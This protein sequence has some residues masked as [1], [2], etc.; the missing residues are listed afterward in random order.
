MNCKKCGKRLSD[1]ARY[2]DRCGSAVKGAA[3]SMSVARKTTSSRGGTAVATK[4][5]TRSKN[6]YDAYRKKKMQE[7]LEQRRRRRKVRIAILWIILL[8]IIGAV[9][10]GLYAYTYMM[11]GGT[12]ENEEASV[13]ETDIP[14]SNP[15]K[16]ESIQ[17]PEA[18]QTPKPTATPEPNDNNPGCDIYIDR[19]YG[20]K[21]AYP[22]DFE[23]GS[24]MNKN[25]RL[26]LE[27]GSGDAQVLIC[28]EKI[29]KSDTASGLMRDYVEGLGVDPEFNR[30]G[31]KWYSVTF[32]RNGRV[33]HRKA[34]I[35][36]DSQFV[37][38]DFVYEQGSD[39]KNK[40]EDYI[41]YMDDYL[42]KQIT[43][44]KK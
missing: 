8:A 30:A 28:H 19:A 9:G 42:E 43:K 4:P 22:A 32:I 13:S 16:T 41:D 1:K 5:T 35:L 39:N 21:C 15:E 3:S 11:R 14:I 40:Y 18:T 33:Q 20:F 31:D 27:D 34:V 23:T 12:P 17:T 38:Y 25:T 6:S 2:C 24:L 44:S 36:D 10:G 37:Y 7:E 29:N 26:S